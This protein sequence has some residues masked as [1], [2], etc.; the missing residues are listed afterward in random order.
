[1]I[2]RLSSQP[3]MQMISFSRGYSKLFYMK[4][5]LLV[6]KPERMGGSDH[7]H[8]TPLQIIFLPIHLF[9]YQ[10]LEI[11]LLQI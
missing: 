8:I 10:L 9:I 5:S 3:G 6:I 1:M 2:P 11:N 4:V 7:S